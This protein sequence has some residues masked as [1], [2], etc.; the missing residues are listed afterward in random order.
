MANEMPFPVKGGVVEVSNNTGDRAGGVLKPKQL[1]MTTRNPN[2]LWRRTSRWLK[3]LAALGVAALMAVPSAQAQTLII[4]TGTAVTGSTGSDPINGYYEAMRYQVVYLASELTAGGMSGGG[5]LT[6]LGWSIDADYAG[7]VLG[8]YTISLAHTAAVNSAT[9]N[10]AALT[11]VKN[12]FSYNPTVTAAGVFDMIT[13]DTP[14]VWD[15]SSNILVDI[16]T[17]T[18]NAYT[19]PYGSVRTTSYT[20]GSRTKQQDGGTSQCAL[21]TTATN[22][23]RPNVQFSYSAGSACSAP[24]PGA[25]TGP[26]AVC[27]GI[28]FSLGLTT[29]TTGS[30]VSYVW[31]ADNG[32]GY[33]VVGGNTPTLSTSQSVATSYY[34]DVTCSTGPTTTSSGILSVGMNPGSACYCTPAPTSVDG[35]GITNVVYSTVSNPTGAEAGNYGNYSA[36]IGDVPQNTT[37]NVDITFSTGYTYDTKIWVDWNDDGDFVD[38]GEEVY[39]GTSASTS[40]TTLPASFA[41]GTNPLGNHRMRIGGQDNG[42]C[43]PCYT[44]VYGAY[45]DYTINV[46][47]PPA[48]LPTSALTATSITTSGADLGWTENGSATAWDLEIG[49]SGFTPTGIPTLDDV[50]ANPYTWAG[51]SANTA[52]AF[53]VRADCGM[54]N[55]NVSSWSGPFTFNTACGAFAIPFAEGFESTTG[56]DLPNC[57]SIEDVNGLTT[58][59]SAASA[60]FGSTRVGRY[61]YSSTQGGDDWLYTPG[62]NLTGG[63]SYTVEYSFNAESAF[64]PEDMDVFWGSSAS[65]GAMTNLLGDHTGISTTPST[66]SYA[67]TPGSSGTYYIGFHAK[68]AA[69][70][71]YL[72]LDDISVIVTPACPAPTAGGATNETGVGAD[73]SWTE[74]GT[75]TAWDIEIGVAPLS[76]TGVPTLNDVGSNPYTW[77]GGAAS[78]TYE[79]YVRADCN[80]D[81]IDVSSWAGPFSFTTGCATYTP[82][83]T[84]NFGTYVPNCWEEA[85]G[86]ITGPTTFGSSGWKNDGFGNVGS[87]GSAA[88]EIYFT[89]GQEWLLTPLFDLSVGGYELNF[90]VALTAWAGTSSDVIEAD[91]AVYLMQST[92]GGTTWTTINTWNAGNS[93]SNTGDNT[94]IDISAVTS[95]TTQFGFF[96]SEGATSGGDKDFFVDNFQVRTPPAC[97]DVSS[98]AVMNLSL[99]NVDIS[100]NPAAGATNYLWE[101]QDSPNAQGTP[102]PIASGSGAGT[103]AAAA[104]TYVDGNDYILYVNSVCGGPTGNYQSHAFT[105]NIPP[106]NDDCA[107]A[108][109][110]DS[111]SGLRCVVQLPQVRLRIATAS[112]VLMKAACFG[113][114]NDDVWFSFVATST[115]R[116][117]IQH[118]ERI[119]G[120]E[121]D[122]YHSV[123]ERW[124]RIADACW[125]APVATPIPATR[126]A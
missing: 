55:V 56:S 25:T 36:M 58:W 49:A 44:G 104:G 112:Q 67:F 106:A 46:T 2:P 96:M 42:P 108:Y 91:D 12:A 78:T 28:G 31:Y 114:E 6:G 121:T 64:Y 10:S 97:P 118:P 109:P 89:G 60:A 17:G 71:F 7:G 40:P 13:F 117:V 59:T 87:T 100:W 15:G 32:S 119:T 30:G 125:L 98:L 63:T 116:I 8:N 19:S 85:T 110:I 113:T 77:S 61:T 94:T 27:S 14:F 18:A 1:K 107:G 50:G 70:Q 79:F 45:E 75:A 9:H 3:Y 101:I 74:N 76:A 115:V 68:S 24:A 124:L 48:C 81:D 53:Y 29:P 120:S 123:W 21:S 95:A 57:W 82:D 88:V 33:A 90:D 51:G 83:Y 16:C 37:L 103:S 39:S 43:V 34:C 41:V 52:Y 54:D 5:S 99:T 11:T 80:S 22:S 102:G 73:L 65:A 86:P 93:P 66:V 4:G 126:P 105:L 84:E 62:L 111:E 23:N 69:D 72:N 92:D 20:S 122:M 35:T 47:A 38:L 26:S